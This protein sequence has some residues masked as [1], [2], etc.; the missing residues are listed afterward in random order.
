MGVYRELSL[1]L[2]PNFADLICFACQPLGNGSI[3]RRSGASSRIC[4]P[5]GQLSK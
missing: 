4:S 3:S 5:S 1:L 2:R